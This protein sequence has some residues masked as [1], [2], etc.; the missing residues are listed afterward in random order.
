MMDSNFE[1]A[2][3]DR[4]EQFEAAPPESLWTSI[5]WRLRFPS[6]LSLSA[7]AAIIAAAL[8]SLSFFIQE[9]TPT[10]IAPAV[11]TD[12]LILLVDT[13]FC[14]DGTFKMDTVFMDLPPMQEKELEVEP[15]IEYQ[16]QDQNQDLI[17][18][19]DIMRSDTASFNNGRRLFNLYCTTCHVRTMKRDLTG[20]ALAGV[21]KKYKKE[22]LYAFTR[23]SQK[24]IDE[25]DKQALKVWEEWAP[26]V[27]NAFP[28]LKDKELEDIYYYV[29]EVAALE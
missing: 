4:F 24:M 29:E 17:I 11:A 16:W 1:K 8:F 19:H 23:D 2:L 3:R 21:T 13:S 12:R 10:E 28:D 15:K 9:E 22:W 26:S 7:W 20:P 18:A 25:G 14:A 27:M 6:L 5:L